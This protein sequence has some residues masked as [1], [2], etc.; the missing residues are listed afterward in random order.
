[1]CSERERKTILIEHLAI[2][3]EKS[4]IHLTGTASNPWI[5]IEPDFHLESA[6]LNVSAI[7][8]STSQFKLQL[9]SSDFNLKVQ[10]ST[11]NFNRKL[12]LQAST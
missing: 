11:S 5:R 6:V 9:Q 1:M 3:E 4:E 7:Q 8:T 10:T 12:Q 2:F